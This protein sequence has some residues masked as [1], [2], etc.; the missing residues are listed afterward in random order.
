MRGESSG[1]FHRVDGISEATIRRL[2]N[3]H[4]ILDDL[5]LQGESTISSSSLADRCGI[6][7]AQVRKDFSSFGS[8]GRRGLGYGIQG[9]RDNIRQILGIDSHWNLALV[10]A[11]NLGHALFHYGEFTKQGFQIAAIFD[12][13]EKLH[14]SDWDG[15]KIHPMG[16]MKQMV[17]ELNIRI[18]VLAVPPDGGQ[19]VAE[20]LAKV[21]VDG[22]LN[23][24]PVK[25]QIESDLFVRNV[26]LCIALESLAYS[27][28]K[29]SKLKPFDASLS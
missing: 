4:R 10:G 6:T 7:S 21:G 18:G 13:D 5:L 11:G 16:D 2:S 1:D 14:G 9:L 3:Y 19:E 20:L 29:K 15:V 24:S 23:F 22:I 8:F 17:E 25:L 12:R 27:I 26:N 28:S